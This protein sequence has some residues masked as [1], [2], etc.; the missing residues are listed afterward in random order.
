MNHLVRQQLWES[1]HEIPADADDAAI[2]DTTA[3]PAMSVHIGQ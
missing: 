3:A 2:V 1:I